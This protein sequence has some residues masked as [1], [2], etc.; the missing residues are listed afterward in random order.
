MPGTP[1]SELAG[2]ERFAT[3]SYSFRPS[4]P[5]R[6]RT[7]ANARSAD[8]IGGV[9]QAATGQ[10][11]NKGSGK[12]A[13]PRTLR[14]LRSGLRRAG[15]EPSCRLAAFPVGQAGCM[16]VVARCGPSFLGEKRGS[17]MGRTQVGAESTQASCGRAATV[18]HP[19]R[20]DCL[21]ERRSGSILRLVG[22][23]GRRLCLAMSSRPT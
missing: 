20:P 10:P 14:S 7:R 4:P 16:T 5:H 18:M 23:V 21:I 8:K 2:I 13:I 15:C 17:G 19:A 12:I 3:R 9:F 11:R 22:T 6:D 1:R